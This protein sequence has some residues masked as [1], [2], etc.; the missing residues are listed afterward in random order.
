MGTV[1]RRPSGKVAVIKS[2]ALVD[3]V[4]VLLQHDLAVLGNRRRLIPEPLLV[5]SRAGQDWHIGTLCV[6]GADPQLRPP[7]CRRRSRRNRRAGE[8]GLAERCTVASRA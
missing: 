3:L 5:D 1:T 8:V 2:P 7:T 6:R 4:A